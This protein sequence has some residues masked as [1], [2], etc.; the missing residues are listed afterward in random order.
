MDILE[1]QISPEAKAKVVLAAGKLTLTADLDTG[2]LDA[3]VSVSVD[4]DYF[5]DELAKKIPG[6]ID[7]AIIAVLK[8]AMKSL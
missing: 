4:T 7:D 8:S 6:Q 5:L 2:G 3:Q 1:K